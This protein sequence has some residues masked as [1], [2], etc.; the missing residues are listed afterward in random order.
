[1][2]RSVLAT[3]SITLL[4]LAVMGAST[5]NTN[6]PAAR[7]FGPGSLVIPMDN[8]YQRRDGS[9]PA[10]TV[11]CTAAASA[12]DGVLRAY[13]L[14]Y[15]LLKNGVPV[16]WAVDGATPKLTATAADV[17]VDAP[18]SGAVVQKLR[19]SDGTFVDFGFPAATKITYVGGPFIVDAQD[20]PRALAMMT[21]GGDPAHADFTRFQTEAVVDIHRV[22]VAFNVI[23]VRPITT[24]PPKI[25]ILNVTPPAG[26]KT[27]S[28]VMYQYAVAAG[29][30]W[31]CAGTGDCAGGLGAGCDKAAVLAYLASPGGDTAIPQVCDNGTP[32]LCAPN[33][34]SGVGTSA[35]KIYDVLCDGDFIPPGAGKTYADTQLAAGNYKLLWI[36]HW[37]T[38]GT[39]PTGSANATLVPAL[40]ATTAADKLAWQLRTISSFVQAGN[41]VFAECLGIQA[42]EGIAGQDNVNG[43][44]VGIPATR[45]QTPGGIQKWNG[46]GGGTLTLQPLLDAA[47]PDVQIGD[48]NFNVVTGAITTFFPRANQTPADAYLP[49]VERFITETPATAPP[50]NWDVASTVQVAGAADSGPKGSVAYLGGHDYSPKVGGAPT[51]G[52]TAGTRI[53]LNTLFNLGF[54]CADPNTSCTTG[55]L[56]ACATGVL[57]CAGGGGLQCVTPAPG[58]P[59]CDGSDIDANCNGVPDRFEAE[60]QHPTCAEGATQS[61]YGGPAGTDGVGACKHGT[62]TCTGGVWGPC[63]GEVQPQPEVC[64]GKDDDCAGGVDDG[65][66]CGPSAT[67]TGGVCLPSSCNVETAHCPSGYECSSA[68]AGT[69]KPIACPTVACPA[70]KV[71]QGGACVDPCANVTCGPGS[72]CSGGK[73][74][75]GGCAIAPC[76][77]PAAPVCLG[78]RCVAD[79]CDGNTCPTGTFCRMGDCVR[80]CAYVSCAPGQHCDGDGFCQSDC[81]PACAAGQAC[82]AGTCVP[83]G[84]AGVQCAA[85]QECQ[86]GACVDPACIHMRCPDAG[87]TCVAGQCIGGVSASVVTPITPAPKSAGGGCGT[88]GAGDLASLALAAG[89]V[90]SRRRRLAP[91]FGRARSGAL[92]AL[93]LAAGLAGCSKAGGSSQSCA[94]GQTACGGEC[95]DLAAS[96]LHCGACGHGCATG[97]SCTAGA[98]VFPTGNPFVQAVAPAAFGLG[99]SP[100]LHL[101]GIGFLPGAKARVEGIGATQELPL[102][103]ESSTAATLDPGLIDMTG[104]AVGE[105]RVRV[106][107]PGKLVSNA[108]ALSVIDAIGVRSVTPAFVQ[109]DATAAVDL[110][111]RGVGFVQGVVVSLTVAGAVQVLPT[112]FTGPGEVHATLPAP[113]T[114]PLGRHALVVTIPGGA[115]SAPATFAVNEGK[116][117]VASVVPP[118][119]APTAPF[120]G[121]VTGSFLYP[122]SVVQ[123]TGGNIVNSPLTTT[124]FSG[125]DALGRC[126]GGLQVNADLSGVT[127]GVYAVTVR[128]P[129]SPDPLTSA[130]TVT[131]QVKI[132]CP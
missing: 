64:N 59:V 36:P 128:N 5:C 13:G 83:D 20:A 77:D 118:A 91:L 95:A 28:N 16:Y 100:A 85:G 104:A 61:C 87:S 14:V 31:P 6:A 34:N 15:F 40:P 92:V 42:L 80:S 9:T 88:G 45:F 103:I 93:A 24:T 30:S 96:A 69:C 99:A 97:F 107:N 89:A 32:K 116:P 56:G 105:G 117:I 114:L 50:S 49:S 57:K 4:G 79:A 81:S 44:P 98:C 10:Q 17:T 70:G 29:L 53:V 23:Q 71:C 1:M 63:A 33:F 121:Q 123:V 62:Q 111:V 68:V 27:A 35:G 54:A 76:T 78:G 101:T 43:G 94:S 124:C 22:Q 113:N 38:S 110:T 122:T 2:R 112:T 120:A 19:W 58:A 37:D 25:A 127:P 65:D 102:T 51:S 129:G 48:F 72:S 74:V 55:L 47:H 3:T 115:N 21:S 12:D 130:E 119:C 75:A 66:L 90:W 109:Q 46:T 67:C 39:T 26:K 125:T 60:C 86:S 41:N 108:L 8:C 73:C 132:V 106:L 11:G 131:I 82:V 18:P 52:Q 84:C 126:V 7:S